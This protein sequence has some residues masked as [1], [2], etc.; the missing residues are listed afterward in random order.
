MPLF[1]Q[2]KAY[3][4]VYKWFD[5]L[6][7]DGCNILSYVIMPNHLHCLLNPTAPEKHLNILISEGKR[8]MAYAIV[9]GIKA[10]G[11]ISLLKILESGVQDNERKKGKKHQVFRLSFDAR[12]C[13]DRQMLEQKLDYIHHNPVA[14][15][16]SLVEDYATYGHSSAAYYELGLENKYVTNYKDLA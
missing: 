3:S 4:A 12:K 8:F 13:Y 16:W 9:K 5:H 15:K 14:G 2:A 11:D 7:K 1:Q 6:L 10:R